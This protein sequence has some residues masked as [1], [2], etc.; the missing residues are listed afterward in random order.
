MSSPAAPRP[1][2]MVETD[3]L[4]RVEELVAEAVVAL[5]KVDRAVR[6]VAVLSDRTGDGEVLL[7]AAELVRPP[8]LDLSCPHLQLQDADPCPLS[9]DRQTRQCMILA[10]RHDDT[11][12]TVLYLLSAF[13]TYYFI[14]PCKSPAHSNYDGRTQSLGF[15]F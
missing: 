14:S 7:V 5:N 11:K 1:M 8:T 4:R 10:L 13:L 15:C 12:S 6:V 9:Q 3:I 2:R